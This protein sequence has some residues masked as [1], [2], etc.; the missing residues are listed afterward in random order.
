MKAQVVAEEAE[1]EL[2]M[3]QAVRCREAHGTT[4]AVVDAKGLDSPLLPRL[5]DVS[6]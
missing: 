1:D 3:P 6:R 2:S 4:Y 5:G